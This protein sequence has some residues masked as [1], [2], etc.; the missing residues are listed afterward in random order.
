MYSVEEVKQLRIRFANRF[1]IRAVEGTLEER[2]DQ[3]PEVIELERLISEAEAKVRDKRQ[4]LRQAEQAFHSVKIEAETAAKK[5]ALGVHDD[6][7]ALLAEVHERAQQVKKLR[8]ENLSWR[9]TLPGAY[10]NVRAYIKS[11]TFGTHWN[12]DRDYHPTFVEECLLADALHVMGHDTASKGQ[13]LYERVVARYTAIRKERA[14][15]IP[16][17]PVDRK[18]GYE[19]RVQELETEGMTR[20]DAQAVADA[21]LEKDNV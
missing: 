20:S 12:Q 3:T 21:E 17:N 8:G 18:D 7:D 15:M 1:K 2:P 10:H 6:I 19:Q 13:E 16:D 4:E 5:K 11:G 14:V 9:S